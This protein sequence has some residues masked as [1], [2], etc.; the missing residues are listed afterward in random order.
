MRPPMAFCQVMNMLEDMMANWNPSGSLI[1]KLAS[2]AITSS[3]NS[4]TVK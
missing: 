3:S 4:A 2:P 1:V